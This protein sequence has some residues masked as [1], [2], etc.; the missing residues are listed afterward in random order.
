MDRD[1]EKP[2]S[3]LEHVERDTTPTRSEGEDIDEPSEDEKK[4]ITWRI[5]RRLVVTVGCKQLPRLSN[6]LCATCFRKCNF[7]EKKTH[8]SAGGRERKKK[9]KGEH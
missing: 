2:G 8:C 3:E 6:F 5:D 4:R 7:S 1:I 9:G